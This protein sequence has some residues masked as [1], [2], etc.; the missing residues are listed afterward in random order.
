MLQLVGADRLGECF[1]RGFTEKG[2]M[3]EK[4]DRIPVNLLRMS[5]QNLLGASV[6][7]DAQISAGKLT[8]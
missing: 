2:K 7:I 4:V 3:T 8:G 6:W 1:N 5:N